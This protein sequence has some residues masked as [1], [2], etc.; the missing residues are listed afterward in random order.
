[1]TTVTEPEVDTA[2]TVKARY[3]E[4]YRNA[5]L[6]ETA[7]RKRDAY[8]LSVSKLGGCTRRGAYI[9]AGTPTTDDPEPEPGITANLGTWIHAGLLPRM[10]VEV[11]GRAEWKMTLRAAGLDIDGTTDLAAVEVREGEVYDA[12]T[13]DGLDTVRRYGAYGDHVIN[14]LAYATMLVQA[15]YRISWVVIQYIDRGS[16]DTETFAF[17]VDT[18]A[19]IRV[20][21]RVAELVRHSADPSR[22]PRTSAAGRD[23]RRWRMKGPS[24]DFS[25]CNSCEWLKECW[26]EDAVPGVKGAQRNLIRNDAGAAAAAAAYNAASITKSLATDE[27]AFW[28][29]PLSRMVDE[30]G[31]FIAGRFR[32]SKTKSGALNVKPISAE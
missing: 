29:T 18:A 22:A 31:P 3:E 32:V 12:K 14:T 21:D 27:A 16:G 28:H 4:A 19:M 24:D 20:V 17:R 5:H 26:G 6:A 13:V 1:M 25:P 10:A 2:E 30:S 23:G 11:D 9:L 8:N 7:S 15:G